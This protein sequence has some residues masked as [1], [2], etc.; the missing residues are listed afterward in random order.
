MKK[1]LLA[2]IMALG[3]GAS[4]V[5]AS[6]LIGG[7]NIGYTNMDIGG[8][9]GNGGHLGYDF[10]IPIFT[11]DKNGFNVGAEIELQWVV[12]DDSTNVDSSVGGATGGLFIGYYKDGFWGRVGGDYQ[13]LAITDSA[14]VSGFVPNIRAGWDFSDRFGVEVSYKTGT[15]DLNGDGPG[16]DVDTIGISLTIH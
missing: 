13:Y 12:M 9:S 14:Y 7:M 15:L 4:S 5:S 6:D 3:F 1:I 11:E 16:V 8:V 2:A 10:G